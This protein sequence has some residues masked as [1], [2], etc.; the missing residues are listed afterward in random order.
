MSDDD[1]PP[2]STSAKDAVR[3]GQAQQR[4]FFHI[5]PA[6]KRVFDQFPLVAYAPNELPLRA[7]R[8]EKDEHVLYVFTT[9]QHAARGRPSFNP[10]CLRWQ[11]GQANPIGVGARTWLT[12]RRWLSQTCLR[13]AGIPHRTVASNNHASPSG[14]LPFLLPAAKSETT[15]P[16]PVPS[17]KLKRW[18]T[19]QRSADKKGSGSDTEDVRYEAYQ[20]LLE[21]RIRIAWVGPLCAVDL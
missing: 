5:P 12:M 11:V 8:R 3:P 21:S 4:S 6:L 15:A 1:P 13:I 18:I 2:T 16:P 7:S 10:A 14:A 19:A 17:N 9:D 20:S